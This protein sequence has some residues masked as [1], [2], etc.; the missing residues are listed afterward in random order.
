ME[1]RAVHVP[2][3]LIRP[4]DRPVFIALGTWAI[5]MAAFMSLDESGPQRVWGYPAWLILLAL[6]G[7]LT[8]AFTYRM[9]SYGLRGYAAAMLVVGCVGRGC[10]MLMAI[11]N[12]TAHTTFSG[13]LGLGAWTMLGFLIYFTWRSRVPLGGD[14]DWPHS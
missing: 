9:R 10:G 4:D 13:L 7:V 5:T 1:L 11:A 6:G 2:R 3:R 14:G 8:I 12:G